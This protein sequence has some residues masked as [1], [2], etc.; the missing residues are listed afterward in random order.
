MNYLVAYSGGLDSRCL[1]E[2]LVRG[3]L[4]WLADKPENIVA[5]HVHHGLSENADA[6]QAHC[7]EVCESL[8]L[9][10]IAESVSLQNTPGQSLEAEAR[11][12]RYQAFA[13]HMQ[14][15]DVLVT[16][17]HSDDQAETF[18]L[19]T[20]RG[21]GVR[22]LAAMPVLKSFASGQHWRPLLHTSRQELL[23]YAQQNKLDWIE[24]ESNHD[25]RFSRN[26]LRHQV[27][28]ALKAHWPAMADSV[29]QAAAHCAEAEDL[30]N[31]L[32][33][34][35]LQTCQL[36]SD[37]LS[38][39]ALSS[40]IQSR[41]KNLIRYWLR[42][43][44]TKVPSP[45]IL[46]RVFDELIDARQDADP[47]IDLGET[48]LRRFQNTLYYYQPGV[49]ITPTGNWDPLQPWGLTPTLQLE[50]VESKT[51]LPGD[52]L[53]HELTIKTR[54]EGMQVKLYGQSQHK[55]LKKLFQEWK[56][57][58]WQRA[59]LPLIFA[60]EFLVAA[61]PYYHAENHKKSG[62]MYRVEVKNTE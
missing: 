58:T 50:F 17:H 59:Q 23:A 31:E 14:S 7:R 21:A 46:T 41:Q 15:N 20:L 53:N 51:G 26:Y 34:L 29:N 55:I 36:T 47:I 4:A 19:Q 33:V 56:V 12:L 10:F 44:G 22:G 28:P 3:D 35:D 52:V 39:E 9:R 37:S 8:G 40:L 30:L 54:E 16:A 62:T 11:R 57:P 24:D 49:T 25:M 2:Q 38:I 61:P 45:K 42:Q 6:W 27:M 13:K 32:A 60:R 48:Q 18:L 43:Q 5:I 1:L